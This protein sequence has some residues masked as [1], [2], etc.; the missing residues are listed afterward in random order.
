[1]TKKET[2]FIIMPITIPDAMV[3]K[4]RDG[5][6]HFRHVL[7]VL[8]IP[9]VEKAGYNANPPTAKGS[10]LIHAG[11]INNL[12]TAELVLCDMSALNPNM[13]FEFGIRTA[14]NR[15]VCVVKD[16]QT[17][18]IPFDTAVLNYH[19]YK[20]S[21]EAWELQSEID[22]LAD[23]IKAAAKGSKNQ[24][25]L[26][27]YFGLKTSASPYA[28]EQGEDNKI[29]YL[30]MKVESLGRKMEEIASPRSTGD[31][32]ETGEVLNENERMR[33]LIEVFTP[34]NVRLGRIVF[35]PNQVEI[36]YKGRWMAGKTADL[37]HFMRTK[38]L[39]SIVFIELGK[40]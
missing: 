28:L 27:K 29:D 37:D 12:E 21:L 25:Q 18:N 33:E 26:W 40:D 35:K 30:T 11:I 10:D 31:I 34:E 5:D 4:Y 23:H 3:E 17:D 38:F 13:F 9:S 7:E 39:R 24:N 6:D 22:K 8:F 32:L 20:S 2:C 14:L 15:P 36:T 16:D 1:M 19:E